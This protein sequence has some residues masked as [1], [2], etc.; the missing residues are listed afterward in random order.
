[1]WGDNFVIIGLV[2]SVKL[3]KFDKIWVKFT[4]I[5]KMDKNY[6]DETENDKFLIL[7]NFRTVNDRKAI[8]VDLSRCV[9]T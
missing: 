2:E 8:K 7:N 9:Y 3:S 6:P 5:L 4:T 1:M